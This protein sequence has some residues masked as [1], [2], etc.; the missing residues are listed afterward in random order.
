MR[1][2]KN[3]E[4]TYLNLK[5]SGE[6]DREPLKTFLQLPTDDPRPPIEG[7]S[8]ITLRN[9]YTKDRREMITSGDNLGK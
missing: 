1:R 6:G 9:R 5:G 4:T 2:E 7:L 8:E 3:Y